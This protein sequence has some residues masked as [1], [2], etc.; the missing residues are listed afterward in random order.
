MM[1][2]PCSVPVTLMSCTNLSVMLKLQHRTAH[3]TVNIPAGHWSKTN[4]EA[5]EPA[6]L[7]LYKRVLYLQ[8]TALRVNVDTLLAM[9]PAMTMP[10]LCQLKLLRLLLVLLCQLGLPQPLVQ[11]TC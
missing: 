8:P 2:V 3:H 9:L 1:T 4:H 11:L 5:H 7:H 10:L 6:C